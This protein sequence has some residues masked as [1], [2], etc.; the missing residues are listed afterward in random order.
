MEAVSERELVTV[1]PSETTAPSLTSSSRPNACLKTSC[2]FC[3]AQRAIDDVLVRLQA[4]LHAP[5]L[6]LHVD[7][8]DRLVARA[9]ELLGE[10]Q[11]APRSASAARRRPCGRAR[12]NWPSVGEPLR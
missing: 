9:L 1:S 2:S 12:E 8:V 3:A 6:D 11:H 7:A 10:P 5:V 4:Q